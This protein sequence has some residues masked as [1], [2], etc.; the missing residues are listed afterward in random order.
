[1]PLVQGWSD[2][3]SNENVILKSLTDE[4]TVLPSIDLL[5]V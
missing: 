2:L 3:S 4:N 1:M 5:V